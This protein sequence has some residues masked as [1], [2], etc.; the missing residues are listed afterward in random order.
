MLIP[1]VISLGVTPGWASQSGLNADRRMMPKPYCWLRSDQLVSTSGSLVSAWGDLSGNNIGVAQGGTP[2]PVLSLTGGAGGQPR[3]V[4]PGTS[5][6][7]QFPSD[8]F[9]SLTAAEVFIV[10]RIDVTSSFGNIYGVG[11]THDSSFFTGG[12]IYDSFGST[13]R[14]NAGTYGL[15]VNAPFI[16]NV[17]A[18]PDTWTNRLNGIIKYT[19]SVNTVSFMSQTRLF[20]TA[21]GDP[22]VYYLVGDFYEFILFNRILTVIERASVMMYLKARYKI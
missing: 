7:L 3:I 13:V 5:A 22:A 12:G 18:G 21:G 11:G 17:S 20:V 8:V 10:S 6:W 15:E 19:T 9:I 14:Y 4:A 2:K 1:G 16:Y